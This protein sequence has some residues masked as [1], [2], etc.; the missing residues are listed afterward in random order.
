MAIYDDVKITINLNELVEI[1]AKL[2][3]QRNFVRLQD[4]SLSYSFGPELLEKLKIRNLRLFVSGK[5]L[6]TLTKWPG[7]D[8]ETGDGYTSRARPV[9]RSISLGLNLD[10]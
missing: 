8:P 5:N 10:F 4:I 1:R 3:T 6:L 9:L 2:L 7:L